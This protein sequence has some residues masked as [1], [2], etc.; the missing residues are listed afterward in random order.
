MEKRNDERSDR[1]ADA[2]VTALGERT[3]IVLWLRNIGEVKTPFPGG[4]LVAAT[5]SVLAD[6]I[7]RGVHEPKRPAALD[8]SIAAANERAI[9]SLRAMRSSLSQTFGKNGVPALPAVV[10]GKGGAL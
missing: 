3:A 6:E 9:A 7:E 8:M 10:A 2:A 5:A 4:D 1:P